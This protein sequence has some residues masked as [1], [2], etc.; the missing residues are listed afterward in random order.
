MRIQIDEL[1]DQVILQVEGRLAGAWVPELEQCW[2]AALVDQPERKISVDLSGVTC[3][4]QAGHYLLRLMRREGV[5]L[6]GAGLAIRE[7]LEM[8]GQVPRPRADG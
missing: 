5:K 4:D 7:I 1:G 6:T 8:A 2:H 3:V